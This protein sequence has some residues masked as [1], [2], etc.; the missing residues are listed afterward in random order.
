MDNKLSIWIKMKRNKIIVFLLVTALVIPFAIATNKVY[1]ASEIKKMNS[2][3]CIKSGNTV[4]C[5]GFRN[6]YKVSLKTKS[7]NKMKNPGNYAGAIKLKSG[8]L[9]CSGNGQSAETG[10]IYRVDIKKNKYKTLAKNVKFTTGTPGFVISKSNVYYTTIEFK[11]DGTT[12]YT[13]RVMKL[14][15]KS[16]KK[17]TVKSKMTTK[18]TNN[19]KYKVVKSKAYYTD[20][21]DFPCYD[22]YLKTPSGKIFLGSEYSG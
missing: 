16:K 12:K 18:A 7:V 22:Y 8:F 11:R 2:Y 5:V 19:S 4:Y 3:K 10:V 14:N 1:A 15:G 9:Y 17:T 13:N 20:D 21:I 6:I